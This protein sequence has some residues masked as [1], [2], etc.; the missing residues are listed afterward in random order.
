[1][2]RK[3]NM[4]KNIMNNIYWVVYNLTKQ[5]IIKRATLDQT[6]R[7]SLLS[8]QINCQWFHIVLSCI[9]FLFSLSFLARSCQTFL[10]LRLKQV[11]LHPKR[12]LEQKFVTTFSAKCIFESISYSFFSLKR[13]RR[14]RRTAIYMTFQ[15]SKRQPITSCPCI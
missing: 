9:N 15:R 4:P 12:M 8:V 5:I 11:K 7:A 1:M 10:C 3:T 14:L 13:D 6:D 2:S